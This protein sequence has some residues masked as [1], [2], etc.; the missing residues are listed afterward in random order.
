VVNKATVLACLISLDGVSGRIVE[1]VVDHAD[2]GNADPKHDLPT[3]D[4]RKCECIVGSQ[5]V[6]R[7]TGYLNGPPN[8]DVVEVDAVEDVVDDRGV[9]AFGIGAVVEVGVGLASDPADI[10][11]NVSD[12]VPVGGAGI[13]SDSSFPNCSAVNPVPDIGK[14]TMIALT[15]EAP[16][17]VPIPPKAPRAKARSS[18][19]QYR[20]PAPRMMYLSQP[21]EEL[22]VPQSR[23][24]MPALAAVTVM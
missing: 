3:A 17:S 24:A 4:A 15:N 14:L 16:L 23:M 20:A 10:V 7:P 9:G 11:E 1:D 8:V 2:V 18:K 22:V 19:F 12:D 6:I 13:E 5:P 21:R